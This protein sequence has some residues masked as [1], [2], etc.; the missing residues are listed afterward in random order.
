[1]MRM[2]PPLAALIFFLSSC[3]AA[4]IF[5]ETIFAEET[6]NIIDADN[7]NETAYDLIMDLNSREIRVAS[8]W[9]YLPYA[10]ID[11]ISQEY[12]IVL[13]EI[14]LNH[15]DIMTNL[16]SSVMAGNPFADLV[17]VSPGMIFPAITN[18][19]IYAIQEFNVNPRHPSN[20][21]LGF[22]W[23]LTPHRTNTEG[24]YLGVN[25]HIV[26]AF[27]I[28]DWSFDYFFDTMLRAA[29]DGYYGISGVPADIIIHLIAANDGVLI[30]DFTYALDDPNTL[31]ALQFVENIFSEGLWQ[32]HHG[33]H[34]WQANTF[35]FTEGRSAFFPLSEWMFDAINF[36][37]T[38]V[39][40][41]SG[42]DNE[43]GYTYMRGFNTGI[44]IPR[45][46]LQP[47]DVYTVFNAIFEWVESEP[48]VAD[49]HGK[50]DLGL[51][52]PT[53]DWMNIILA[54]NLYYG[55]VNILN[56]VEQLRAPQ[57]NIID[58]ALA[59]WVR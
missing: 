7:I 20:E 17:L 50:F 46:T 31:R 49:V 2:I 55:S 39:P 6:A 35:A 37:H 16:Q 29:Q 48:P 24:I 14:L 34:D 30:S 9:P 3:G 28:D 51:A 40:F 5:Y 59:G 44:A 42:P 19:L 11:R 33:I 57:Q 18:H 38:I 32:P 15:D 54:E 4:E 8:G 52:I 23:T 58:E 12:N 45:G 41:P 1:M 47:A 25:R 53:F 26:R 56:L 10:Q 43:N 22:Y 13:T 27:R 21:F 36:R